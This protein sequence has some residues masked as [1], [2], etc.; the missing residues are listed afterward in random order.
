LKDI[1]RA[2]QI[3]GA[4]LIQQSQSVSC[5]LDCPDCLGW[6]PN[7]LHRCFHETHYTSFDK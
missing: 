5:I 3:S 1:I 2:P 4:A 6:V 7:P